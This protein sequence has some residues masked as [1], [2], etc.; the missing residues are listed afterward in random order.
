MSDVW[1]TASLPSVKYQ[2]YAL[3]KERL[4][5]VENLDKKTS[6][7]E[8]AS[9]VLVICPT[10]AE[11]HREGQGSKFINKSENQSDGKFR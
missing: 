5:I 10:F 8:V 6:D 4:V 1:L 9:K 2:K 7:I 3:T 11:N